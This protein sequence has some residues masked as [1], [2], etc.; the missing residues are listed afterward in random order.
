MDDSVMFLR[1]M[2]GITY[3]RCEPQDGY[4]NGYNLIVPKGTGSLIAETANK[5]EAYDILMGG[6]S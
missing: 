2:D 4:A 5:A 1:S 6:A 3:E